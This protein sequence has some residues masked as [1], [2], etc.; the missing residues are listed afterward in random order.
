M[1]NR[2]LILV[3]AC[4]LWIGASGCASSGE[5]SERALEE[6]STTI[7]SGIEAGVVAT[8]EQDVVVVQARY[9]PCLCPAPD[10]EVQVRG[11][12]IRIIVDGDQLVLAELD[13]RAEALA[14]APQLGYLRLRGQFD[15]TAE[16]E[17]TRVEYPRFVLEE[18]EIEQ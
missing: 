13:E 8:E 2:A 7:L 11:E 9:N 6:G 3:A 10:Y 4:L 15:D 16:L 1:S 14:A 18:F 5:P 12:W 17:E